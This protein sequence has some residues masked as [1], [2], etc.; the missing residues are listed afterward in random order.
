MV[1]ER[2]SSTLLRKPA[3]ARLRG[4]A[5]FVAG[6]DTG[7]AIV[8]MQRLATATVVSTATSLDTVPANA[9]GRDERI[10]QRQHPQQRLCLL[11]E[12]TLAT[13]IIGTRGTT[14]TG[15]GIGTESAT[16]TGSVTG[17]VTATG[18]IVTTRRHRPR[19]LLALPPAP[20]T[21]DGAA[22]HRFRP[23]PIP[24]P[25]PTVIGSATGSARV[26][27]N[28]TGT[29]TAIAAAAAAEARRAMTHANATTRLRRRRRRT[30]LTITTRR[31]LR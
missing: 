18:A 25:I 21:T 17:T 14:E 16:V 8:R 10:W 11:M 24:L 3:P 28:A 1:G 30:T 31:L 13:E 22:G 9:L 7:L 2:R 6:T 4:S 26:S 15:R 12:T 5:S 29:G 27:V 20:M 19:R 23:R